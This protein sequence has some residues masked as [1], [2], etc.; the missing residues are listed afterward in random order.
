MGAIVAKV[1]PVGLTILLIVW[2]I[3]VSPYS[4]Y[5]DNWAVYP[6]V[7]ILPAVLIW[8]AILI[9]IGK[10]RSFFIVYGLVHSAVL[11]IAWM[12]CLMKITK[13]SL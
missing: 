3:V 5:G 11:F 13:D 6:A 7:F 12:Y 8:H 2:T 10:P 9:Y 4:K 1:G